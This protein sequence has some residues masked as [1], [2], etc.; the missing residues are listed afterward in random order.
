MRGRGK[1][2]RG[3]PRSSTSRR[4]LYLTALLELVSYILL[5]WVGLVS[6][7][8]SPLQNGLGHPCGVDYVEWYRSV[9]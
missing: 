7:K 2:E 8:G 5:G 9:R 4:I 3:G 1:T 6:H